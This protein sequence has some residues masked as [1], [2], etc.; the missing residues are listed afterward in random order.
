VELPLP[1]V[2]DT[3]DVTSGPK[4]DDE[5]DQD[6]DNRQDDEQHVATLSARC[7]ESNGAVREVTA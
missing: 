6:R 4:D 7:D 3:R 2:P 1:L 5:E